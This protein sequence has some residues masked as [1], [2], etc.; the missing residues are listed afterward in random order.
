M[1]KLWDWT[2]EHFSGNMQKK[3]RIFLCMNTALWSFIPFLLCVV[4]GLFMGFSD[5][6]LEYTMIA[7]GYLAVY[8][9]FFGG[10]F[11]V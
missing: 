2:K 1:R 4:V 10:I 3:R 8:V 6:W 11:V 9:G 5:K 7:T